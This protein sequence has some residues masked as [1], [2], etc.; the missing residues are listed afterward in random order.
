[1]DAEYMKDRN[2]LSQSRKNCI[3]YYLFTGDVGVGD[4]W[5]NAKERKLIN[6]G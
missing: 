3:F 5:E 6:E 1:M 2:S 4:K